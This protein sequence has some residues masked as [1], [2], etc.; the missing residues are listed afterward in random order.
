[1]LWLKAF[2]IVFVV[3]WFAG[4]FGLPRLFVHHATRSEAANIELLNVMERGMF[5]IMT[6]GAVMTVAFGVAMVIAVPAYLDMKWLHAKLALVAVL[7]GYHIWC[8]RL[9]VDFRENRNRRSHVWFRWF[10]EL[11]LLPLIAIVLLVVIKPF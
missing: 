10:N 6:F 2:H 1:M 5:R 4:L 8:Y 11:A 3:T 7:I 9:L